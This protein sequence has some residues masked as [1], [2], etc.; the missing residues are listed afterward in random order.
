V[1][2]TS[3]STRRGHAVALSHGDVARLFGATH[4]AYDFAANDVW[5]VADTIAIDYAVW[6]LW[7]ELREVERALAE[8]PGVVR[9]SVALRE[10]APG[11]R[12]LVAY[13]VGD[14]DPAAVEAALR[15][16][17]PA[18]LVPGAFV[19]VPALPVTAI[20]ADRAAHRGSGRAPRPSAPPP[21][22][23]PTTAVQQA[24]CE[25]AAE[26]L[27]VPRVG[28]HDNFFELGGHSLLATQFVSRVRK[29]LHV[30]LTVRLI[31]KH[32]TIAQQETAL[33]GAGLEQGEI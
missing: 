15:A 33:F 1:S 16:R 12:T 9:G 19:Q 17:L 6:E 25:I 31:F 28:I 4:H 20:A 14:A 32:P 10:D 7:A 23:A 27:G 2:Y 26:L 29:K 13:L 3:G 11:E 21:Y 8:Q 5:T 30:D 24:M 22:A 18:E